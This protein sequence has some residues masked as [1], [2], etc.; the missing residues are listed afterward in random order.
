[1][2][3]GIN[4]HRYRVHFIIIFLLVSFNLRMSFSAADPLLVFL[5]RDLGLG[6]GSSGLFGLLPIMSLGIAAPLGT[7]LVNIVRPRL[8]I[9]YALLFAIAGVVWRSYGGVP[10]LY[11]GT[12]AIGLGL[13]ITGSVILGIVKQVFPGEIPILMGAYTAC[14]SLGTAVGAGAADVVALALGGWQ[15]GLLFWGLPLL[16]AVILWLELMHSKHPP[17]IQQ[18]TVTTGLKP[19][20]TQKKAWDVSFFYL[21]RV[22]GAWLLI[23]WMAALMRQRGL[24]TVE[25][26]LVLALA[27]ACQIPGALLTDFLCRCLGKRSR[28][29]IIVVPLSILS[30]WGILE[31]P[32]HYWPVFSICFGL[33]LGTIFSIGMTLIVENSADE[34][35]TVALSGMAQG[36]GFI[37]GGLLAWGASY[38]MNLPRADL[39]IALCYTIF[40]LAGL[41]FGIR[42][43]KPGIVHTQMQ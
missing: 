17:E 19:L 18:N 21:F 1:M 33:S 32:L 15:K 16:I 37:I 14:V 23:V 22:A 43:E 38:L 4:E 3:S 13:G 29:L 42:C 30:C 34:A 26:G 5:M 31:A 25:S 11:G 27:T 28:L 40:A 36:L 39:W 41:Y 6:V 8:L 24:G 35:S 9:V 10:G 20:L 12:I 2:I 7:R